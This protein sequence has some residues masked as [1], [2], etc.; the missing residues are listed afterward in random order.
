MK[1]S[2]FAAVLLI[3]CALARAE[4]IDVLGQ[5]LSFSNPSGYCTLGNTQSERDLMN[6]SQRA[7]GAGSRIVHAAIR[8]TEIEEYKRGERDVL[9][10]WLQIQLI[11]PKGDFKRIEIGRETFLLGASKASPRLDT[12]EINRRINSTLTGSDLS[13]SKMQVIPIGRDGNAVYFSS[14]MTL[15]VGNVSRPVTGLSGVTLVNSL[16]LTINVYEGTGMATSREKLRS[17]LHQL[18]LSVL[19]EN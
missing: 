3:K 4:T 7:V 11:G 12:S 13:L 2:H 15:N 16:P 6:I 19:T 14:R 5:K 9:D 10:H 1:I 8:C 17:T 18:L